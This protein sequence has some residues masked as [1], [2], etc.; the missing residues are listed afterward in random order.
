MVVLVSLLVVGAFFYV[1][2]QEESEE[3]NVCLI[4]YI[5]QQED[6]VNQTNSTAV[7]ANVRAVQ[8][9]GGEGGTFVFT[10]PL[11]G[12]FSIVDY[13]CEF[14][15]EE[16]EVNIQNGTAPL[17]LDSGDFDGDG[18]DEFVLSDIGILYPSNLK[19]GRVVMVEFNT[20]TDIFSDYVVAE[21]L[22]RVACADGGDLDGDG[23]LDLTLCEFG[24]DEGSVGWLENQGNQ[25]WT[26]HILDEK[27]GAIEAI[28]IDIDGDGDLDIVSII[29]QLDEEI[30]V[31]WNNGVGGF[32]GE[33]LFSANTTYFGMSGVNIDD[34]EGDGDL[35]IF[36]TNGDMLDLDFPE[37][38]N[39]WDYHG[40]SVLENQGNGSFEYSRL[41]AFSGA[42]DSIFHD[43]DGDGVDEIVVVGFRP[44]VDGSKDWGTESNIAWLDWD[45][46]D[47]LGVFPVNNIA[48]SMI[49]LESI[50][51]NG[52]GVDELLAANHDV[53]SIGEGIGRVISITVSWVDACP[54][55]MDV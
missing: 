32:V 21:N 3:K 41:M 43:I 7:V 16:V 42:Y 53:Y 29:S 20:S 27:P 47:W 12:S 28:P 48:T 24:N 39:Y 8:F 40:L 13:P 51:V 4:G 37:D 38:E 45:G 50:D 22:G 33:V 1:F 46:E 2:V 25:N 10:E 44:I 49:S 54:T 6:V 18:V 15:C 17:R 19:E 14:P 52:D 5:L 36:F 35:D 23:D 26:H 30:I 11:E 34:L 31:Y 55:V 9:E